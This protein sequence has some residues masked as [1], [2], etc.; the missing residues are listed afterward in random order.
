MRISFEISRFLAFPEIYCFRENTS[1]KIRL[2]KVH[3]C[4]L[5]FVC[6]MYSFSLAKIFWKRSYP[7]DFRPFWYNLFMVHACVWPKQSYFIRY[8]MYELCFFYTKMSHTLRIFVPCLNVVMKYG[9]PYKCI[10]GGK[11]TLWVENTFVCFSRKRSK[12]RAL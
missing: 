7:A 12:L 11:T 6:K 10:S 9:R 4:V 1:R 5:H 2:Q 3:F 8:L